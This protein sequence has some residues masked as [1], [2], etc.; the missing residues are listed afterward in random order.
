MHDREVIVWRVEI[1]EQRRVDLV[2]V[3]P[4]ARSDIFEVYFYKV[5]S[6][7]VIMLMMEPQSVYELVND[8]PFASYAVRSIQLNLLLATD[9]PKV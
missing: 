5:V 4:S 8:C 7:R 3:V 2:K 9:T 6:I 1:A